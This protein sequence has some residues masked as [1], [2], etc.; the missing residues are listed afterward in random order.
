V[1]SAELSS[2][3]KQFQL[4]EV[5]FEDL[6]QMQRPVQLS[7]EPFRFAQ[8]LRKYHWRVCWPWKDPLTEGKQGRSIK[9]KLQYSLLVDK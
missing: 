8:D 5:S 3:L 6:Q 9:S 2:R 4:D 1:Q 7:C